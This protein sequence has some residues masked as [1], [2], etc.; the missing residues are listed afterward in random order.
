MAID[1]EVRPPTI[2]VHEFEYDLK[3][4]RSLQTGARSNSYVHEFEYGVNDWW[5]TAIEG[6]W[7]RSTESGDLKGLQSYS[8]ENRFLF[9]ASRQ[10]WGSFGVFTEYERGRQGQPSAFRAGPAIQWMLGPTVNVLDLL[11]TKESGGDA[12]RGVD[13][14]YS[15]QTRWI[16]S[17]ELQPGIEIYGGALEAGNGTPRRTLG[18]P[19]FFGVWD[20]GESQD[21]RYE[22]GYLG[23]LRGNSSGALKVLLGYEYH[24]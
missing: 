16:L 13:G 17:E 7:L 11:A 4:S 14:A 5:S 18:G 12:R 22:V 2:D 3:V 20:L 23:D 9:P 8:F 21:I 10:A 1:F 15:W 6:E 19:V 24:F